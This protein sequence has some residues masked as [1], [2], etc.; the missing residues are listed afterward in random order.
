M[1]RSRQVFAFAKGGMAVMLAATLSLSMAPATALAEAGSGAQGGAVATAAAGTVQTPDG[2]Y[3]ERDKAY[4]LPTAFAAASG[5]AMGTSMVK[6]VFGNSVTAAY[7][8]SKWNVTL[9]A[10][11]GMASMVSWVNVGGVQQNAVDAGNGTYTFTFSADKLSNVASGSAHIS[12]MGSTV[13]ITIAI[14]ASSLPTAAPAPAPAP[15]DDQ[16]STDVLEKAIANAEDL[17]AQNDKTEEANAALEAAIDAAEAALSSTS[18]D[19]IDAAV[20]ALQSAVDAFNQSAPQ[21]P[22]AQTLAVSYFVKDS[23]NAFSGMLPAEVQAVKSQAGGYEVSVPVPASTVNMV[24]GTFWMKDASG[25]SVDPDKDADGT[26]EYK[27]HVADVSGAAE[28][29]FGYTVSMGGHQVSNTHNMIMRFFDCTAINGALAAAKDVKDD[30]TD[31]YKAVADALAA[32]QAVVK[33]PSASKAELD[34]AAATLNGAIASYNNQGGE[35]PGETPGEQPG[36]ENGDAVETPG[37]FL[38]VQGKEYAVPVK[39]VK[40]DGTDSMAAAYFEPEGTIAWT[41]S[42]YHVTFK[43]TP[44]GQRFIT[45]IDGVEDLG[46]GAYRATVDSI[47][48]AVALKFGLTVPGMGAMTQTGYLQ[49]DTTV[50]PTKSGEQIKPESPTVPSGG[51]DGPN[52]NATGNEATAKFQVGHT[53]QV[54][55]AFMKHNSS[56]ASMAAKYFGDT[57]LVRPQANGTFQ[58]SFAATSEGLNYIKSLSHNGSAISRSGDQFTLSIPSAE[59]DVVIPIEMSV[60]MMEQLG[61]GQAQTADM[62]LRLSQAKDLGTG[63]NGMAASSS[64]NLAKT[65]DSSAGL[66]TLAGALG[67]LGAAGAVLAT[68]RRRASRSGK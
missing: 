61:I 27:L 24:G 10:G 52:N 36:E 2:F 47:V 63:A 28:F 43:V 7:D 20:A 41:G 56:E 64:S 31:A 22:Q 23:G 67:A 29:S 50:L 34:A 12:E 4:S 37:G 8:G 48:K 68:S 14:D 42:A 44:D 6:G 39:L 59:R 11:G 65:G 53:Y 49:I 9:T 26:W 18:Q 21:A 46:G 40:D 15:G 60:T 3:V 1:A 51:N 58:V 55:I 66:A 33:N 25:A 19:E 30:G 35:Q 17:L 32:A 62:H 16:V 54:P 45:S 13:A 57:A 38:L 5:S